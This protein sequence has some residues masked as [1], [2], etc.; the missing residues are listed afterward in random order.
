MNASGTKQH[1]GNRVYGLPAERGALFIGYGNTLRSDDGVGPAVVLRLAKEHS[2]S[3]E[4]LFLALQQLS[5]EL[6]L[7]L[8]AAD[9][10]IFVDASTQVPAGKIKIRRLGVEDPHPGRPFHTSSP[11]AVLGLTLALYE[12]APIAWSV[13]I[14]V[15]DL[16]LG[17]GL[18]KE[19][20]KCVDRLVRHLGHHVTRWSGANP[21]GGKENSHGNA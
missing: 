16:S 19:V 8:C 21:A 13:A 20:R 4:C 2:G 10:V 18:S 1:H 14:G 9:R 5:P 7:D 11:E 3:A 6:A 17:E 12:H 15:S